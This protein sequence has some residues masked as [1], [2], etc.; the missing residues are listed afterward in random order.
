[1]K[2]VYL[3][4]YRNKDF[5]YNVAELRCKSLGASLASKK[6]LENAKNAGANWCYDGHFGIGTSLASVCNGKLIETNASRSTRADVYCYGPKPSPDFVAAI[7]FVH[8]TSNQVWSQ[9]DR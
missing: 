1:M 9:Y 3:S 2:E 7:P 4:S 6:E 8:G 5:D